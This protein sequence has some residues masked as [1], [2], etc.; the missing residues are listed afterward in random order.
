MPARLT[1]GHKEI[2]VRLS[3]KYSG[4]A[5]AQKIDLAERS[6]QRVIEYYRATGRIERGPFVG[7]GRRNKLSGIDCAVSCM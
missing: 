5:I 4:R 7:L 2:I 6:V 1:T 3:Q